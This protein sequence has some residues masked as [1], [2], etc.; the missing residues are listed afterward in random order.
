MVQISVLSF[1]FIFIPTLSFL[2]LEFSFKSWIWRR[3][4]ATCFLF[5]SKFLKEIEKCGRRK[6][7]CNLKLMVHFSLFSFYLSKIIHL[8]SDSNIFVN[9][10]IFIYFCLNGIGVEDEAVKVSVKEQMHITAIHTLKHDFI[11]GSLSLSVD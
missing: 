11:S 10:F 9:F 5:S 1:S 3:I 6:S 7:I 2:S 8:V 4:W